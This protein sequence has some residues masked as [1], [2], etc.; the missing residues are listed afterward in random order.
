MTWC[1]R[2]AAAYCGGSVDPA[3]GQPAMSGSCTESCQNVSGIMPQIRP[4]PL[5]YNFQSS[6][7]YDIIWYHMVSAADRVVDYICNNLMKSLLCLVIQ[8]LCP[9]RGYVAFVLN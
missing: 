9:R 7:T 5:P 3:T 4:R 2:A 1:G 6:I 8:M